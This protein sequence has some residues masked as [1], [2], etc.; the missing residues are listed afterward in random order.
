M[1]PTVL[2]KYSHLAP[3]LL[4]IFLYGCVALP[5]S[6]TKET[7]RQTGEPGSG[8]TLITISTFYGWQILLSADGPRDMYHRGGPSNNYFL[9]KNGERDPQY[10]ISGWFG[11]DTW[12]VLKQL[13]HQWYAISLNYDPTA[14]KIVKFGLHSRAKR[15]SISVTHTGAI[16]ELYIDK[17]NNFL[18][19]N[20]IDD[21][22]H[23]F[24]FDTEKTTTISKP[25]STEQKAELVQ[26]DEIVTQY[27]D[28]DFESLVK[29][30]GTLFYGNFTPIDISNKTSIDI[31]LLYKLS[32]NYDYLFRWAVALNPK[33]PSDILRTLANDHSYDVAKAARNRLK[34][35]P[36]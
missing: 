29:E 3:W 18:I 24:D 6:E 21:G 17:A 34:S 22:Y 36:Y 33:T 8:E 30:D 15:Y 13:N 27:D 16:S 26:L 28:S 25:L 20:Q 5:S 4:V 32:K 11:P 31:E 10:A 1:Q 35:I 2:T 14:M 19:W 9:E 12:T 23:R 7:A